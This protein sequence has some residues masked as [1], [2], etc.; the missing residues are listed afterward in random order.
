LSTIRQES[1]FAPRAQSFAD[2]RGLMQ[3]M[4]QLGPKYAVGIENYSTERLFEPAVNIPIG[5]RH[6]KEGFEQNGESY[7]LTLAAYNAG[8]E[9]AAVW[10]KH[11]SKDALEFIE[12]IP[13]SETNGYVKA[14][15]RN[16][17]YNRALYGS[18]AFAYPPELLK[19]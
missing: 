6:L 4:P 9:I 18:G 3:V 10:S 5:V 19:R 1:V 11:L 2:A 12:E 16:E 8:D 13:F 17:I 7:I 14:I 15:L